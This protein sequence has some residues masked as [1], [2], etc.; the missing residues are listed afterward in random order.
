MIS[1]ALANKVLDAALETGGDYSELYMEDAENNVISMTDMKVEDALYSRRHGAGVRVLLNGRSAYA[2]TADT[3]EDSL[4]KTARAAAAALKSDAR[5]S[6]MPAKN[7]RENASL[8]MPRIPF[9]E[10]KNKERIALIKTGSGAAKEVSPLITQVRASYMDTDKRVFVYSSSGIR[11]SDRRFRTRIAISAVASD[12]NEIQTG[13]ESPGMGMG[14]EAYKNNIDAFS[15]GKAAAQTA[16]TMLTAPD[17]PSGCVPV[18]IDGGFGGVIL[19]EACVHSLEATSVAKGNSEFCGKLGEK[20]ASDVVT[21][22]DDGTLVGEWGSILYDDEGN[23]SQRNVLIENGILK[24]YLVDILGSRLMNHPITGS[25]RRQNYMF[26]PTSRMTNTFFAEGKD[27][28]DEMIRTMGN[29]LYAKKM[30]GGSVNPLTGEFNF[31]VMEGYLVKDGKIQ[32]PLRGATLVGKGADVLMNID[33]VGQKMWF[34]QG[35]CGSISGSVPTNVG[36]PPIRV[37]MLTVG[38]KGKTQW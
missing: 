37:K 31:A 25:A 20:I 3:S 34:G 8:L 7:D 30:G 27:D 36:Q 4:I 19:H 32:S 5:Y 9:S 15:A 13:S 33:R 17:C 38:G 6:V 18:V 22:V 29:G 14:F 23:K 1:E 11:S 16:I 2:Y 26:A 28:F 12:G 21:A 35:M 24:T 10:V